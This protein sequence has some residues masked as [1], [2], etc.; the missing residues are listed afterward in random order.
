MIRWLILL[1]VIGSGRAWQPQAV[2]CEPGSEISSEI[3][4]VA[5]VNATGPNA[6]DAILPRYAALRER[7]PDDLF[8][9]EAYQAVVQEHGIEGYLQALTNE[10][11]AL[12]AR[13]PGNEMYHYLFLRSLVGRN[14]KAA[15][16]GLNEMLGDNPGFAPASRTLAEIYDSGIFRDPEKEKAERQRLSA[17]CPNANVRKLDALPDL[18]PLL[19]EAEHLLSKNGDPDRIISMATDAVRADEWRLQRIRPF[20]WYTVAYKRQAYQDIRQAYWRAWVLQARCYRKAGRLT[21][22]DAAFGRL[23]GAVQGLRNQKAPVNIYWDAIAAL[24]QLYAECKQGEKAVAKLDQMQQFLVEHPDPDR[25]AALDRL[26]K[27][28]SGTTGQS[29]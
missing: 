9:N 21:E 1:A 17:L 7:H 5:A 20:D 2:P 24:A 28:L 23:E 11:E 12:Q 14:T 19:D 10:Y 15:I 22:A 8:V 16:T 29:Q 26:R 18:S 13:H 25:A 4:K 3:A 27:S 6:I